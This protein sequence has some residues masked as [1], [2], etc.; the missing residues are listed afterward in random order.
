MQIFCEID[1]NIIGFMVDLYMF[2]SFYI[3]LHTYL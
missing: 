3:M 1:I 2:K